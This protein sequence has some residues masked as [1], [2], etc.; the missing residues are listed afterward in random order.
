M[1]IRKKLKKLPDS[2]GVYLMK[3]KA[4]KVIYIGKALSLKK[5]VLSYFKKNIQDT[6]T[7]ILISNIKDF[8]CIPTG[9]EAEALLLEWSLIKRYRPKFNIDLKDDKRYP[10]LKVTKREKFPRIF[11]ARQRKKD[12]SIYYGRYTNAKL[13]KEALAI[14]RKIFPLRTCKT[15][16]KTACLNYHIGQCL[17]PCVGRISKKEYARILKDACLFLEGKKT[18]LVKALTFRMKE[19]SS[20]KDYEEAARLR[21]QIKALASVS[22]GKATFEGFNLE[23]ITRRQRLEE[24]RM[25]LGLAKTPMRIEAFD[26]SNVFG[27]EAVGSMVSFFDLLADKQNYKRFKIKTV[28]GIDDYAMIKEIVTRRYKRLLEEHKP[29]PDLILIDGGRS[30]VSVAT[31]ALKSIGLKKIPVVGIAK[32]LERL[33]VLE[34]KTPIILKRNSKALQ[35]IQRI[36]DE[37][38]RFAISYHH[39]LR[40]KLTKKSILDQIPGIGLKRK[41]LLL[42][43]CTEFQLKVYKAVSKVPKGQTCSYKWV[44]KQIGNPDAVRAV[45]NALNKN[46]LPGIIPCHRVIRSDGTLGGFSKGLKAKK[47]LLKKENIIK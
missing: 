18:Q 33:H 12:G 31:K 47:K 36:R 1:D 30:H 45:G 22:E 4:G 38:H 10:L 16:P 37:A 42:K 13:L 7:R 27:S 43:T 20:K 32:K 9:S 29:L 28:E 21:D 8:S 39:V 14:M 25:V 34:K 24:L 5:R 35:L 2:P 44:A 41:Q 15:F 17:A 6:K 40:G 46:P 26:V 23:T 19:A 3:D 11:I